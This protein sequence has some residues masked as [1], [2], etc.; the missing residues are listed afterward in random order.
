MEQEA[1]RWRTGRGH[2]RIDTLGDV[3]TLGYMHGPPTI[4]R[5]NRQG[6][7]DPTEASRVD[8]SSSMPPLTFCLDQ[9]QP[10]IALL[11]GARISS[12]GSHGVGNSNRPCTTVVSRVASTLGPTV[13]PFPAAT[14]EA[15]SAFSGPGQRRSIH[16]TGGSLR[17]SHRGLQQPTLPQAWVPPGARSGS[18]GT[19][20]SPIHAGTAPVTG[21][22]IKSATPTGEK[23]SRRSESR[24]RLR[25]AEGRAAA[26]GAQTRAGIAAAKGRQDRTAKRLA[27]ATAAA[28]DPAG[29]ERSEFLCTDGVTLIPYA[30]VGN[31]V[32]PMTDAPSVGIDGAG[33]ENQEDSGGSNETEFVEETSSAVLSFVAVHD[34]FDSLEKTFLLFKPL[35]LRHPGCQVLCFNSPGQAGT[36]LP[37]EPQGLLT[38]VWIADRLDELMQVKKT[39]HWLNWLC[40]RTFA[41]NAWWLTT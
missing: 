10:T 17:P 9:S 3:P 19:I 20:R 2:P 23:Q 37:V 26:Q 31:G 8:V 36:R 38:N 25:R 11:R 13:F 32:S 27:D 22:R 12:A 34:F 30:V 4:G 39:E 14:A 41:S 29:F 28:P 33:K 24:K 7:H 18:G 15:A 5:E 35:V 40:S 6:V 21:S 16:S 1:H